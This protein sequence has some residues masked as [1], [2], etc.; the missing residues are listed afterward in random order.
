MTHSVC[1]ET[2]DHRR[3]ECG[4]TK[5]CTRVAKSGVLIMENCSS[6]PGDFRR[7]PAE[8]NMNLTTEQYAVIY[9]LRISVENDPRQVTRCETCV[10]HAASPDDAFAMAES[11]ADRMNNQYRNSD[12]DIVSEECLGIHDL[13]RVEPNTDDYFGVTSSLNFV[14]TNELEPSS[15]VRPRNELTCFNPTIDDDRFPN[16]SQ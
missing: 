7:Y 5:K 8:S 1:G 4:I 10:F 15:L 11:F 14:S 2:D 3:A 9:V 12:G 13:D 16:L 6:R